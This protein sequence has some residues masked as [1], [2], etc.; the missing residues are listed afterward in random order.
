VELVRD[1]GELHLLDRV[2]DPVRLRAR[3]PQRP[4]LRLRSLGGVG[5]RAE[6]PAEEAEGVAHLGQAAHEL[7]GVAVE[8]AAGIAVPELPGVEDDAVH[9]PADLAELRGR[10]VERA[11]G[12]AQHVGLGR[13]GPRRDLLGREVVGPAHSAAYRRSVRR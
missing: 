2:A 12:A 8:P 5:V 1:L 9:P 4:Q 7:L 3:D 10:G 13:V 11:R 6:L